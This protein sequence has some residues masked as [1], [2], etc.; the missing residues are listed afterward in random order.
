MT[1]LELKEFLRG[2]GARLAGN[3]A[4]LLKRAHLYDKK[5]DVP[6]ISSKPDVPEASLRGIFE[7][8]TI[9]WTDVA[10]MKDNTIPQGFDISVINSFLAEV[11]Y[12]V[13]EEEAIQTGTVKIPVK[14]RQ[15]YVSEKIHLCQYGQL[16]NDVLAFRAN[17]E[18]S[19]KKLTR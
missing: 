13:D 18:A 3:K 1:I 6:N 15:M 19:M 17:V 14:G 10:E 8:P 11:F 4:E 9:V 5:S 12:D 2:K 7:D 16:G